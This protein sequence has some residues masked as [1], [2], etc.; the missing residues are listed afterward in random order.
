MMMVCLGEGLTIDRAIGLALARAGAF[1]V[2][3]RPIGS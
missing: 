2:S 3:R 1:R